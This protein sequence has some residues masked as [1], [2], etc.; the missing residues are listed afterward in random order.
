MSSAVPA[1]LPAGAGH[2]AFEAMIDRTPD[3][4][5]WCLP[6]TVLPC[7]RVVLDSF[8]GEMIGKGTFEELGDIEYPG[9]SHFQMVCDLSRLIGV[10]AEFI[11]R[12]TTTF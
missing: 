9:R 3:V 10:P 12:R 8:R 5:F 1:T 7:G 6:L 4:V 11:A 2:V